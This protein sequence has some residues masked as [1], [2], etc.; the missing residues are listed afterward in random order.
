MLLD[1]LIPINPASV[2]ISATIAAVGG[3]VAM[4][5]KASGV[6]AVKKDS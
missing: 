3:A 6:L 2:F 5:T 1:V 4:A